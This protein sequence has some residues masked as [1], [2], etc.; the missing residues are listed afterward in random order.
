[1]AL[2]GPLCAQTFGEIGGLVTDSSGSI[3]VNAKLT[4]IN[5]QT[6]LT[7]STASN[8][9]GNYN[10]P[11][12]PPG[13]YD[14]RAE[15][16]GFQNEVRSAVELQ[17]QQT[18]RIDFSLAVGSINQTV[19]VQGGA[20]LVNSENATV[21]TVIEQKRIEDLP[22]NGRSFVSLIALS[23]NVISGQSATGG[24]GD[25]RGGS[26]RG[27]VSISIAGNR[28]EYQYYTLDGVSDTEV[29]FNTY[30][31]LPSID[32]LQEFKV[33]TGVYSAEFGREIAQV[34]V[35]TRSGT[36]GYHGTLFE[37]LRNNDLDARPFAFTSSVP[38][39]APFK[40]NQYGYTFGGPVRIPKIF[41][42]R[43][44]LF[45]MSNYEGFRL[46]NQS[47]TVFSTA[48]ATMRAG[49]FS[50]ILPGT[51][52]KDPLNNNAPFA[53]NIIPTQRLDP[54]A[55]GLLAFYPTPN[56]PGTGLSNNYLALQ[57]N[58]NDKAQFT[59][60]LDFVES[61]KSSWFAR[62]SWQ[63]EYRVAPF[64]FEDG[65]TVS[66]HVRQAVISNTRIFT[67]TLVNE[68][69]FGW[70]GY[71]N[72]LLS[73]LAF[74]E[75]VIKELNIPLIDPSPVAWGIPNIAIQGF[76]ASTSTGY[77]GDNLQGPFATDNHTFQWSDGLTWTHGA[78]T[79]KVGA[80]IRRDRYNDVGNQGTRG[81]LN[82]SNQATGYGFSDYML[83][84]INTD[85]QAGALAN[86]QLRNTTQAYYA[87]DNWKVRRNL[88]V[89]VGLRY[90]YTAPWNSKNDTMVNTFVPDNVIFFTPGTTGNLPQPYLG[91]N[92]AAYGENTFYPAGDFIRFPVATQCVTGYGS[93]TLVNP[94]RLDFAPR[95]GIAWSPTPRWT[96]RAG[97]G[98]F[99]TQD[100]GNSY[101]DMGRTL[102][103]K[104]S[105]TTNLAT[106]NLT[107]ENPFGFNTASNSCGVPSPPYFCLVSPG[108]NAT[109]PNL[110]NAYVVQSEFN[111]QRQLTGST[112]L[113]VGYL[114]SQGHR[115]LA[116]LQFDDSIEG[117]GTS[118]FRQPFPQFAN[119][120]M[121]AGAGFSNY[122]GGSIKL[123]RR[124][125]RGLSILGAYTFSKSLDNQSAVNPANGNAP[126]APQTGWC[127]RCE[128]GLS[129][130][131]TRHRLVASVLYELPIGRGKPF[132]NHGM[133]STLIGGWQLNSIFTV[134]SGFPLTVRDGI[135]R[136]NSNQA[137]D[138]PNVVP[139]VNWKLNN[140]S[141]GE[142]FNTQAFQ[143][144]PSQ[145]YGNSGRNTIL[146]PGFTAW[147]F[148]AFKNFNI[149][150]QRYLQFRFECFN[151]ANHPAFGDPNTTLT[152][153]S[154]GTITGTRGGIDMRELQFSLKLVF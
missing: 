130:F 97:G 70:L 98:I 91:R 34:N 77:F 146:S 30:A 99:Y 124:L 102:A 140:P 83:G 104:I 149:T 76:A 39:S 85:S 114:G 90:E 113:E 50:Q 17:V 96:V 65:T 53:E 63:N 2:A 111:V 148:S 31:F 119:I 51:V 147:D 125:S 112:V 150:E 40:W 18:A 144:Q 62:Y 49:N 105:V 88:T 37:F 137:N 81:G 66:D 78:H 33:Q 86:I 15:M 82:I 32:A 84:Y 121:Y 106:H 136:S 24:F 133:A 42:G 45:F 89:E 92:C 19:E 29:D 35:S 72:S 68:F 129:D 132:L 43:D 120:Q 21:G 153:T 69:H 151:C 127:I 143:L 16:P 28:R 41:N 52:I 95:L 126:R 56:I 135:N 3:L 80:E 46:R 75:D 38:A 139:G 48:P 59:Q 64:L 73:E 123:T 27:E 71:H 12:L 142:W 60:R 100:S 131:D 115:L 47:Q 5:P 79:L 36:N 87:T 103:G 4:V 22:L 8:T 118:S 128:Y 152:A 7:R 61:T 145:S 10:F 54:I 94:D 138:Y 93:T 58:L 117:P 154:F 57:D 67:P 20:P 25:Q 23:P 107:F 1:M 6:G 14:V 110:R 141:T 116:R 134:S 44:R 13:L 9:V 101:L 109:D 55:L 122:N 11:S 108:V 74:R 26:S